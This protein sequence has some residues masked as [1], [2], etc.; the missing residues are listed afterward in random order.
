MNEIEYRELIHFLLNGQFLNIEEL[1]KKVE[2]EEDMPLLL[3]KISEGSFSFV[4]RSVEKLTGFCT[5]QLYSTH[6]DFFFS[7]IH[8]FDLPCIMKEYVSIFNFQKNDQKE[9]Q[10][11]IQRQLRLRIKNPY[12][13]W[14]PLQLTCIFFTQPNDADHL[15][16]FLE[17]LPETENFKDSL[18]E[19]SERETEVLKLIAQGYVTKEIAEKLHISQHTA[20]SHRKHLISKFKVKNTA[21]LIKEASKYFDFE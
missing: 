9:H 5:H 18:C 13:H 1:C 12:H 6:L 16:I 8:P 4:S 3:L 20:E 10:N 14:I 11:F 21:E 19:I 7:Q 17:L 2:K 15:L